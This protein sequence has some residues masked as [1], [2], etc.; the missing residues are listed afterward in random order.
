MS[1]LN[2]KSFEETI[3]NILE[4]KTRENALAFA[5]FLKASNMITGEN[6]GT[7]VYQGNVL[8]WMHMGGKPEMPGP[9]TIW[10]DLDGSVPE[11]FAFDAAMKEIAWKHVNICGNCGSECAP[12]SRKTI[13]G[14]EFDNVCG[15]I[16]A[17]T[18]PDC[19]TLECVK[20][21]LEL[22]KCGISPVDK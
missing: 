9:W 20:N 2:T 13:Y 19:E 14:K 22:R 1:E 17:F 21:L 8:A 3:V 11:G 18:D 4:G 7:V 6:H 5:A 16:L 10:P 15:A 12:G